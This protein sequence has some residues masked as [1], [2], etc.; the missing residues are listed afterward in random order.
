MHDHSRQHDA[1]AEDHPAP[2]ASHHGSAQGHDQEIA[3]TPAV[4]EKKV[5]LHPDGKEH[6]HP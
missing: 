4:P 5:H 6:V 2:A 1:A 3:G